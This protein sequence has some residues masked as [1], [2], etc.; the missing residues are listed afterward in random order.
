MTVECAAM[1]RD[2]EWRAGTW[3][4][5]S[6]LASTAIKDPSSN[7]SRGQRASSSLKIPLDQVP[8]L[9]RLCA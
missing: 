3:L 1:W 8:C 6:L 7:A 5:E 2:Q 4:I 9:S